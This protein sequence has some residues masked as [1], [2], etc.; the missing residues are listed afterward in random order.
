MFCK[1]IIS[2]LSAKIH[3]YTVIRREIYTVIHWILL[4][5]TRYCIFLF[6][7]NQF[8][9]I[10]FHTYLDFRLPRRRKCHS[11]SC[12]AI[13]RRFLFRKNSKDHFDNLSQSKI[14]MIY[15]NMKRKKKKMRKTSELLVENGHQLRVRVKKGKFPLLYRLW[16]D[17]FSCTRFLELTQWTLVRY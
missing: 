4:Y 12:F 7:I 3:V 10:S 1:W 13:F 5:L 17:S 16:R 2:W 6:R 8:C 11:V 15:W 14:A 9:S